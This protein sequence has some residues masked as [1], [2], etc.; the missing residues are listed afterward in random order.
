MYFAGSVASE[1]SIKYSDTC[2]RNQPCL[3]T[4][5]IPEDMPAPIMVSY[6]I[7]PFF[8]N[9]LVY[10]NSYSMMELM[11]LNATDK[12]LA[13]CQLSPTSL[14][15]TDG[16]EYVPCGLVA[17]SV[18]NDTFRFVDPEIVLNSTGIAR[19]EEVTSL[20]NNPEDY[21][22]NPNKIW[23]YQRYPPEVIS[24]EE[25]VRSEHFAVWNRVSAMGH[26]QKPLGRLNTNLTKGQTLTIE[27]TD[28]FDPGPNASKTLVFTHLTLLGGVDNRLGI[29]LIVMGLLIA[30]AGVFEKTYTPKAREEGF[31]EVVG[32]HRSDTG[33]QQPLLPSGST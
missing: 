9:Y 26:A 22:D 13:Q 32:R 29:L 4:V 8:Q 1:V 31:D 7:D 10:A 12:D 20:F 6:K 14:N 28:R 16:L 27:I 23:L 17:A 2:A 11:G 21:G 18:F 5:T 19:T 25:G 24:K 33:L 15:N 3:Q 30:A